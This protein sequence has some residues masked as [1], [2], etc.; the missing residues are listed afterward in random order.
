MDDRMNSS[1]AAGGQSA[2]RPATEKL[3]PSANPIFSSV[4][5]ALNVGQQPAPKHI[6]F[7]DLVSGLNS[8]ERFLI[9]ITDMELAEELMVRMQLL[10]PMPLD[11][12]PGE[13]RLLMSHSDTAT[14]YFLPHV[15]YRFGIVTE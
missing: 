11:L 15:L 6:S 13:I 8:E 5:S 4:L 14:D 3:P 10:P 7:D 12:P 1:T 2:S 9:E